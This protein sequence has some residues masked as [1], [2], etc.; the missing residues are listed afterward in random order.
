MRAIR[1]SLLVL[2]A[3]SN[4][5][6]CV[7]IGGVTLTRGTVDGGPRHLFYIERNI[8]ATWIGLLFVRFEIPPKWIRNLP[9]RTIPTEDMY[10]PLE[11]N[12][13]EW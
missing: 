10:E 3:D 11:K 12:W 5:N 7:A 13:M 6:W 4:R 2:K 8:G 9:N 1:F